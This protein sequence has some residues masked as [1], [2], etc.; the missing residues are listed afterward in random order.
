MRKIFCA[1]F[2]WIY[3]DIEELFLDPRFSKIKKIKTIRATYMAA[4]DLQ[5][6]SNDE[7]SLGK[8]KISFLNF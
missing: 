1:N 3:G 5:T 6:G 4:Y 2:K 7:N 8:N